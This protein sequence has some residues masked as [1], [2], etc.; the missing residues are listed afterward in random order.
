MEMGG[1]VGSTILYLL[2]NAIRL[3][4]VNCP[5]FKVENNIGKLVFWRDVSYSP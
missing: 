2:P 4:Y 1:W 3:A 5:A